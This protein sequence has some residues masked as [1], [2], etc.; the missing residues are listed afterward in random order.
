MRYL[1]LLLFFILGNWGSAQEHSFEKINDLLTEVDAGGPGV[2]IGVVKDQR[3]LY[4]A[5]KGMAN[6]DYN[7]PI[8]ASSNFRLS[9]TSKQ[10]TAACILLL[11]E[12]GQLNLSD[13]LSKF[14]PEFSPALGRVT[15]EQLLHHTSG[16]RDYMS[17]LMIQGSEK[18]DFFS[19]FIG[20]DHDIM[21]LI[22]KQQSLSFES[23]TAHSYS[24][25]NYWLL[26]QVVER[27]SNQSLGVY[28]QENI[29]EPLGMKHSGYT[30]ISGQI[31]P[32]R[33]SGYVSECPDCDRMEYRFQPIAM[34]DAG[35]VSNIEDLLLWEREFHEH[36]L[37]SD[38]FWEQML[39]TGTLK[40]GTD[41]SYAAGL[42]MSEINGEKVVMHSGQTPGFSSEILRFPD[43]RLSIIVLGNQNWYDIRRY[44]NTVAALFIPSDEKQEII[45]TAEALVAIPLTDQQQARFC[46]DYHFVETNE[47]RSVQV[48]GAD[49]IYVRNN[50]PTSLLIPIAP[51]VLT[52][53]ERPHIQLHF[54][55]NANGTTQIEWRDLTM[56]NLHA[57]SYEK[58]ALT[59]AEN[60]TYV[61]TYRSAEL[62]KTIEIT[63][64][65]GRLIL[66]ILGQKIPL[67]ATVKD[68]FVAMGMFTLKF[69][70]NL[71][72]EISGFTLDA[73][74]AE[75][76]P[77]L[78][79]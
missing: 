34:G 65:E 60:A 3:L 77:F 12:K 22:T 18:I 31:V 46:G 53:K 51:N 68:Q 39:T 52:F 21:G 69:I 20:D 75:N 59:N 47:Y 72:G 54:D 28:A 48:R 66:T 24:N 23:G 71:Q 2:I 4:T 50:G 76:I 70:R 49:L 55:F 19:S 38:A 40:D 62:D 5:S 25:T 67:T 15:I 35:V 42:M 36:Q 9:S 73:P 63:L 16:I 14:F 78:R 17:L 61:S 37:M 30:E 79:L 1:C 10:F 26:G 43:H 56:G 64:T 74:R 57:N 6:L 8:T 29:F 33:V 45:P 7:I 13:S 44:A 41:L 11:M 32:E 58:V 27:V